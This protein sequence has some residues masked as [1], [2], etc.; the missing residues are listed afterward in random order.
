MDYP[1]DKMQIIVVDGKSEDNT[2]KICSEFSEKYPEN[3]KIISEK[4]VKGKP[5]A[6]NLALP[7]IN[8]EIVGVF[9]ADSL[10]E[11]DVLSKVVFYFND[12]KVIGSAR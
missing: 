6:L 1:K 8:G 7:Y 10:P 5:A 4:T 3:I 12:K 9:D 2:L 11:K